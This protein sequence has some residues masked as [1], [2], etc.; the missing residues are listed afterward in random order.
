MPR[1]AR[2]KS[3][4]GI[5]HVMLRGINLQNIFI[6][7]EDNEKFIDILT[8]YQKKMANEIYAYCL[9]GNHIHLLIKE[10]NEDLSN[11]IRR[12]GVSYVHWYNW[13]Y[14]RKGHL[15][16]DRYKADLLK[17]TG[18]FNPGQIHTSESIGGG[19]S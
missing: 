2:K 1:G 17:V 18:I 12:I 13:Q 6:D 11:T 15:F 5:Y 3:N 19:F 14:D 9:M 16:Q 10:G 4:T 8:E 7:D